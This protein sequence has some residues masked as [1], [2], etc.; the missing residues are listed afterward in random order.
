M[1]FT[2]PC[3]INKHSSKIIECLKEL[4]YINYGNPMQS[5]DF[6]KIFTTI[7][8]YFVPYNIASIDSSW[9]DCGENEQLFLSLAALRDDSDYMQWFVSRGWEN[10]FGNIEDKWVLC[11]KTTLAEF[12]A[13]NNSPNTYTNP[14]FGW[15][16]AT[17]QEL[18][19]HFKN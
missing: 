5:M 6:S 8:G 13:V 15:N 14:A 17:P 12:G 11:D 10:G 2:T 3:F 7:D 19:E 4:G 9:I 1:S 16:K 18:I